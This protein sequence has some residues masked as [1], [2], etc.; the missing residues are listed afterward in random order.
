MTR[1]A[2]IVIGGGFAGLSAATSLAERG[3]EVT[4]LEGRQALG[5][6]AYSFR[7]AKTGDP[8]DNGQHL[9]MGCYRETLSFLERIGAQDR[10]SFQSNLSIDF[11]GDRGRRARLRCW[12]LPSPWHLLSGL[13]RLSTLS[14]GDRFRL[15]HVERALREGVKDPQGLDQISV[16][17]WLIQAGQSERARRHLWDL[18]AIAALNE[19]PAIASAAPFVTVLAQAFFERRD[20]SRL[21]LSGVG[22]SDLYA[23]PA[24]R[25]IEA[26][27]GRVLLKAPVAQIEHAGD[28][29]T[30]VLLR[31]GQRLKADWVLSAVSAAAFLKLIPSRLSEREPVFQRIAQLGFA[32]IISIH[33]WFD[34]SISRSAFAGLLDTHIQWF[35]N[36]SRILHGTQSKEGYVSL[37]ISG[38]RRFVE[39]SEARLLTMALEEL[40]RLMPPAREAVLLRSLVIKEHQAT[41]SPAVG[42]ERLRPECRSPLNRFLIAGDWTRTGLPAT[43]ESACVSGRR[44][45]DMIIRETLENV[46]EQKRVAYV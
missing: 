5:G 44:C 24:Q 12:P 29:V 1:K 32:P 7:D 31:D 30:S 4:V 36:K 15:R 35:F 34:R 27:G 45:A 22:L 40:R 6:R 14:W 20:A 38:A 25:F 19:D 33:L 46:P 43:I 42:S 26:R 8:V 3:F 18:I 41:L 21:G 37:V 11:I 23:P 39:W 17:D 16:R 28:R 9:F 13:V 10:L 2:V